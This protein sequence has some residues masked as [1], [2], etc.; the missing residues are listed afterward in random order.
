[1]RSEGEDGPLSLLAGAFEAAWTEMDYYSGAVVTW[2]Q[3][4]ATR[5]STLHRPAS[6]V[7]CPS[8]NLPT[9]KRHNR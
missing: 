7:Q 2:T 4:G 8:A 3:G 9:A 5:T 6:I 1:M